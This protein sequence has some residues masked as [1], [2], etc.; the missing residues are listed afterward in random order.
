MRIAIATPTGNVGSKVV[1]NL[2]ED[3][4]HELILLARKPEKVSEAHSRGARIEQG[5][6]E[7]ADYVK[8]ATKWVN[9]LF[10]V[11]PSDPATTDYRGRARR[12][13]ENAAS[14]IRENNVERVVFL[15]SM[16][17]HL[18]EGLG[19][20][21]GLYDSEHILR[22]SVWNLAILRPAFFME[23]F[24]M[25][26]QGIAEA[27]S[28][29]MPVAGNVTLPMVATRDIAEVASKWLG[30]ET[31]KGLNVVPIHGPR[32]YSFNEAAHLI[33]DALGHEVKHVRVSYN[34]AREQL[35]GIGMSENMADGFLEM[36][37]ALENGRVKPEVARRKDT[38]TPTTLETFAKEVIAP[39]ISRFQAHR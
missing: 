15:S 38:T 37:S 19:P 13:A 21:S 20:I 10:W 9:A 18:G 34:Q 27:N 1:K 24:L 8:R 32:D 5:D 2:I 33:G 31:W 22:R 4:R 12:I 3:G 16:G 14:A 28:I 25:S 39:A 7:N 36:E 29:F 6:I 35:L 17:A 30:D 26:L 23:N 11:V